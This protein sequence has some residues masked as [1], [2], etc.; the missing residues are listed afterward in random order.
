MVVNPFRK[1]TKIYSYC[2][3]LAYSRF[4]TGVSSKRIGKKKNK[5]DAAVSQG[6]AAWY[7]HPSA[8]SLV[9]VRTVS[10]NSLLV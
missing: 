1:N 10:K 7:K 6:F 5:R 2:N 4:S 8:G 9:V 3:D